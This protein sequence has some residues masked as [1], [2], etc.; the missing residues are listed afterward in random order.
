MTGFAT[1]PDVVLGPLA[2]RAEA[3]WYQAPPGKWCPAQIVHHL[4]LSLE[5]SVRAFED[6]QARPPMRRRRREPLQ[7]LGYFLVLRLGWSPLQTS[8]PAGVRPADHPD[9]RGVEQQFRA[10]VSRWLTLEGRLLPSRAADLFVKH[11]ALG[12][13]TIPEWLRFHVWHCAHHAKQIHARLA[14]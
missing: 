2:H 8:A 11:P 9:R 6:R 10:A 5:T 1:V 14:P 13:L 12:D 3:D 7:R 4:A